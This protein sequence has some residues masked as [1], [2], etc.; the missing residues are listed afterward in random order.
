MS[1]VI[2]TDLDGTVLFS[3]R[4]MAAGATR[5]DPADLVPVDIDGD[6]TYAY[7]TTATTTRWAELAAAGVVVPA[8]TRSVPQYLRLRLPGRAPSLAIVCNGAR[9]LVDGESDPV[10]ER[11]VRRNMAA[12]AA[13]F[14]AVW[15]QGVDWHGRRGFA[16]V[17]AVEDFFLY[18]TVETRE[19]WL[20][21]FAAEAGEWAGAC[22]WRVSLQGRKLYLLPSS[23]DKAAAVAHVAERL[24]ADRVVAGGDSLL[25]ADMLRAADAAIRPAHGELHLT[26]FTAPHCR[27]TASA[28]AAAGDEIVRWY[29]EQT[30]DRPTSTASR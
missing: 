5:P 4:A 3:E 17:R 24:A 15:Q 7:M 12:A 1:T 2:A 21:D 29:G 27:T 13:T 16:A 26:G 8:T 11:Q 14:D 23:L 30:I 22:G 28:G 10:W 9:L 18:L 25:D 20:P 6:R 19:A